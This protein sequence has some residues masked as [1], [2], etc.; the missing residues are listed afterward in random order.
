MI[1]PI[2]ADFGKGWVFLGSARM[3]GNNSIDL[4]A[5]PLPTKPKKVAV[6]ALQD[7]LAEKITSKKL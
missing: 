3:I 1:V 2:Y 4:G 7:V 5:I 6:A